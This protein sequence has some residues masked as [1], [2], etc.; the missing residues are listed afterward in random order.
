MNDVEVTGIYIPMVRVRVAD[1]NKLVADIVKSTGNLWSAE[2]LPI[3]GTD[4]G[5]VVVYDDFDDALKVAKH[6]RVPLIAI[7]VFKSGIVKVRLIE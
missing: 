7:G 2:F 6:Y 4:E 1:A 5:I 3:P